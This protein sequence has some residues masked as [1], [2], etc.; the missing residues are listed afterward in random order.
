M[1]RTRV[2]RGR[3]R[4][5]AVAFCFALALTTSLRTAVAADAERWGRD[6]AA[7]VAELLHDAREGKPISQTT[8][9]LFV[10]DLLGGICER[11]DGLSSYIHRD[12]TFIVSYL[13]NTFQHRSAEEVAAIDAMAGGGRFPLR[14][15]ARWGLES[16]RHI[17]DPD[18]P[19]AVREQ[20]RRELIAALSAL[21]G[22]LARHLAKE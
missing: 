7:T 8:I 11:D 19:A 17:P 15:A 13:M 10:A 6:Y 12:N 21:E 18:G 4:M 5:G 1:T 20:D 3:L 9:G 2:L 16:L 14:L 22:A